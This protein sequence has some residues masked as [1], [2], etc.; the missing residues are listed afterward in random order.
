M[1]RKKIKT[2]PL[3]A[4][5]KQR[6]YREKRKAEFEALKTAVA[7]EPAP[8]ITTQQGAEPPRPSAPDMAALRE[9]I[10]KELRETWEPDLKA[11]RI[12]EQRKEGRKLARQA[13]QSHAQGRIE[14]ICTAA[15]FFI[16]RDRADITKSLLKHFMIDKETAAAAL[17]SDKRTKSLTFTSLDKSGAWY[18]PPPIK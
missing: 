10:K 4:A 14:G 16:G 5:E 17:Q 15:A 8:D 7:P 2:E 11:E 1:G 9:S 18:T 6:R 12:A 3:T 13:D